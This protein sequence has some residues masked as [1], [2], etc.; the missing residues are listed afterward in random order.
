MVK[1][2]EESVSL[3]LSAMPGRK[4]LDFDH[5]GLFTSDIGGQLVRIYFDDLEYTA[6]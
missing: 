2:G 6:K 5:F 3:N 4:A 1:L